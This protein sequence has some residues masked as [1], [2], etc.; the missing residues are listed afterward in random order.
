MRGS[1]ELLEKRLM[2]FYGWGI[3]LIVVGLLS[4]LGERHNLT[5]PCRNIL[6]TFFGIVWYVTGVDLSILESDDG[7]GR[8][9]LELV[10][11][12]LNA[13]ILPRILLESFL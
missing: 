10:F 12:A 8:G 2:K 5:L 9:I 3:L 7:F 13:A 4:I 6:A 1:R 11:Y